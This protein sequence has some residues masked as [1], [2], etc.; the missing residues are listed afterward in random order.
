LGGLEFLPLISSGA[1]YI[2]KRIDNYPLA[3]FLKSQK[4]LRYSARLPPF[5]SRALMLVF[6][7]YCFLL[8]AIGCSQVAILVIISL[9][10]LQLD[11]DRRLR[12][13]R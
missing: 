8:L 5:S 2:E 12:Q 13:V 1:D 9:S 4:Q 11:K 10:F 7:F 3:L 6:I